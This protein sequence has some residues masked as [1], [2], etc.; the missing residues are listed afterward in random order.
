MAARPAVNPAVNDFRV[1]AC[2][3]LK[4]HQK[5][6]T[7]EKFKSNKSEDSSPHAGSVKLNNTEVN[8]CLETSLNKNDRYQIIE[9]ASQLDLQKLCS[10]LAAAV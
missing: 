3:Q 1:I 7:A 6:N 9:I 5:R 8:P 2:S 4:R 10:D